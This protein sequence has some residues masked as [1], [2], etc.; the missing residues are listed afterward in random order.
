MDIYWLSKIAKR[1]ILKKPKTAH[2]LLI[3]VKLVLTVNYPCIDLSKIQNEN[4]FKFNALVIT[5]PVKNRFE[6][7]S[8]E[9]PDACDVIFCGW[10]Q[11]RR[12]GN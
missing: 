10:M 12:L 6:A 3:L 11:T 2:L 8:V 4:K 9:E 1:H 5:G 7:V